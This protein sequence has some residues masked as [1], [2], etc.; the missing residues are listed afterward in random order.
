MAPGFPLTLL[1]RLGKPYLSTRSGEKELM[2][3]GIS[4]TKVLMAELM[5]SF[6]LKPAPDGGAPVFRV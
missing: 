3:L 6:F 2:G 4:I 1:D 5:R